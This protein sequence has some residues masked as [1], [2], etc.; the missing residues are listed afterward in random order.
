M[1]RPTS[2]E[3]MLLVTIG[4]WALNLTVSRYI[5]LH[6]VQPLVLSAVRYGIAAVVFVGI[7]VVAERSLRIARC[8]L[9]FVAAAAGALWINQ[10]GFVYAL[11]TTSAS[12]VGLILGATPI[13][14][15]VIGLVFGTEMLPRRFWLGAALST[16]GV[17][18]VALGESGKMRADTTGVLLCIL[19]AATWVL[20]SILITPLMRRYS[21]SRISAVVLPLAWVGMAVVGLPQ[22]R[23]QDWQLGWEVWALILFA[24]FGPLVITNILWFNSLDRI[25]PSRAMLATNLQPFVA[26]LFAVVLLGETIDA[27]QLVGGVLIGVGILAARRRSPLAP[28][29]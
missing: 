5:L 6:G 18:L 24:T 2:T 14:A 13:F 23:S 28:G 12:T 29:D 21:P 9:V 25:G 17:G 8:D 11:E 27:V 15:A 7:A 16:A 20:Y 22:T 10:I 19:T 26:A 1:R 3:V 4:L